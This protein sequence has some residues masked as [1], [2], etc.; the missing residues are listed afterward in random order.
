ME[1]SH[2]VNV[3]V[4]SCLKTPVNPLT[5][6]PVALFERESAATRG[7]R[8]LPAEQTRTRD[9]EEENAYE[10]GLECEGRKD[11]P[12]LIK[13]YRMAGDCVDL[14]EFYFSN[15]E[16]YRKL[17]ELKKAHLQT[18]AELERMYRNKMELK[19]VAAPD[20]EC[21]NPE[22]F[23]RLQNNSPKPTKAFRKAFSAN[24]LNHTVCSS[25][26]DTS[27]E[28]AAYNEAGDVEKGLLSSPKEHIKN[29]WDDFSVDDY[30]S[31]KRMQS[32]SSLKKQQT[33]KKPKEWCHRITVPKPF[34]MT[35]REAE[36]KKGKFK[37]RSEIEMENCLLKK[38]LEELTE[39]QK[40]F[41]ASPVPAHVYLP[42]F[43]EIN[44]RNE[45]RRQFIRDRNKELLLAS[46][47]PFSFIERERKK[48]E[49]S[50]AQL[51]DLT[52]KTEK[53][54]F[55]AK[56]VPRSVY[57]TTVSE[58]VKEEQLYRAIKMQM[59]AEELLRSS[60]MPKSMVVQRLK[61]KKREKVAETE[62]DMDF[63]PKINTD[64]PDFEAKYR[65]FKKQL[66]SKKDTKPM[67]VCEP[68]HLLT[69]E[70]SSHREKILADI[71]ADENGLRETRWP[72]ISPTNHA[73]P[74]SSLCSS[75]SGS[76]EF[77]PT[78]ITDAVK[79]RQEAVRKSLE[80][81]K[82]AE[83]EEAKWREMQ[84]QR[85]RKLQRV[86][87]KRAQ[88]NDPHQALAQTSMSR[89]KQFR[90]QDQQR[91]KEYLE[92]MREIQERLKERPLLL[93]QVTQKNA[94]QAAEK[95]YCDTLKE[96]GLSEDFVSSKVPGAQ[97]H[98]DESI[99]S[100]SLSSED[101]ESVNNQYAESSAGQEEYRDD[102]EDNDDNLN[103]HDNEVDKD[104]R[105]NKEESENKSNHESNN[106]SVN[107]ENHHSTDSGSD[108]ED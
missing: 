86:I 94:R 79:K 32:S 107:G 45:D 56:P 16:Y 99:S 43:E 21:A 80:Q 17:E 60:S 18:M 30:V 55:K 83:E 66:I 36:K 105:Y 41:R 6:A 69:S 42:L 68:F 77:L 91:R 28:D 11:S 1:N 20:N 40:K 70:I 88:A 74:S 4:T 67:T 102:F 75:L 2:R 106:N 78:K 101:K 89:L 23:C 82:K 58:R 31:C 108:N 51:K 96:Y 24:D 65:K 54:T 72:Y 49:M 35:V 27:D 7:E 64:I 104:K 48:K 52:P 39:C 8:S 53:K 37:S 59:R 33:Q 14:Q 98:G 95:R 57:D 38:Q 90:K 44:E 19:G 81:R 103:K 87:A 50:Q 12:V 34:N 93:E 13:D 10:S 85:E 100:V 73:K 92:E 84:R 25:L 26:S 29:M 5:K 61:V 15:E 3:L 47:K 62:K 46:Q 22:L 97:K 76:Q 63:H 71:E 9:Y